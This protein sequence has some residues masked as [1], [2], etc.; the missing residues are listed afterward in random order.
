M[1]LFQR[2]QPCVLFTRDEKL[3]DKIKE[4]LVAVDGFYHYGGLCGRDLEAM[5]TGF[6]EAVDLDYLK[7]FRVKTFTMVWCSF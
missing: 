3:I 5:T 7:M 2:F 1:N 4:K 6:L